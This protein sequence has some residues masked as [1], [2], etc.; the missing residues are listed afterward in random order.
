[1]QHVLVKHSNWFIM[2]YGSLLVWSTQG[3]E[4]NHYAAKKSFVKHSQHNGT[5]LCHS[6]IV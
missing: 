3:M 2:T 5:S 6:T 1:M 4:K